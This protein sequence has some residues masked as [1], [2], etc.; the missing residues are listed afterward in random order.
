[1]G[2]YHFDLETVFNVHIN[3]HLTLLS[4]NCSQLYVYALLSLLI[5]SLVWQQS[6]SLGISVQLKTISSQ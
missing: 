3:V 2:S 5:E 1:M 4:K 6:D